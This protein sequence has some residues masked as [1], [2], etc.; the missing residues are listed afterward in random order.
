MKRVG[1]MRSSG[2]GVPAASAATISA[3]SSECSA[4]ILSHQ[5]KKRDAESTE[6]AA[7]MAS[8]MNAPSRNQL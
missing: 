1:S 5:S 2:N 3:T 8:A 7:D 6:P 4:S